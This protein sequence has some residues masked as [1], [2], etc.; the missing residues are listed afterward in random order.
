MTAK[1][2]KIV[3]LV[4]MKGHSARIPGKNLKIFKGRPLYHKIILALKGASHIDKIYINTD[5]PDIAQDVKK[6]FPQVNI[7]IRPKDICGDDV[8]MNKIIAYDLSLVEGEY[9]LQT[10]S[11]NPLLKSS[12]IDRAVKEYFSGTSLFLQEESLFSVTAH[13]GRFF[14]IQG[15]INHDPDKLIKTQDLPPIYE[16]NS[17]IY[18]FSRNSFNHNGQR[19]VSKNPVYFP[20]SKIEGIDIDEPEDFIMAEQLYRAGL[21]GNN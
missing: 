9:F 5:S 21:V 13:Q 16:E 14:S 4:P 17:C 3:A 11:T 7:I 10:H 19:R 20:I 1:V 15:P 12:T 18:L 6:H 8:S 2:Q